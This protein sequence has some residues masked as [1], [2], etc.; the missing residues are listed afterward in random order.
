MT[1]LDN[2]SV[3]HKMTVALA[4]MILTGIA[5]VSFGVVKIM[6]IDDAYSRLIDHEAV[7]VEMLAQARSGVLT[8][9]RQ[10]YLAISARSPERVRAAEARIAQAQ[11]DVH[12]GIDKAAALLPA[13]ADRLAAAKRAYDDLAPV[14]DAVRDLDLKGDRDGA[15]AMMS[16]RFD[17]ALD[18]VR[19][20]LT[21]MVGE[22]SHR[23]GDDSDRL[24]EKSHATAVTLAVGMGI[25]MALTL[26]L[27]LTV[28]MGGI[29]RPLNR[30]AKTMGTLAQGDFGVAVDG[31]ERGDEVGL[32]A[33]SVEVFKKNGLAM[34]R[35][36]RDQ[37]EAKIRA[38]EER[39]RAMHSLADDFEGHMK[40]LVQGVAAQAT[41]LQSTAGS[42]SAAAEETSKQSLAVASGA[43]QASSNVQTVAAASEELSASIGEISRQVAQ[44][45]T[46]SHG[47]VDEARRTGGI[48]ESLA[49]AAGKI[50][51][52]VGLITDIASQTNLLALNATI[53]AARAGEAGKG[54]AVVAG[55][56]K[57]LA[58]QTARA[59]DEIS[60]QVGGIQEATRAAVKAIEGI[61]ATIADI[62]QVATSIASAVEQQGA[63]TQEIARNIQQAAIAAQE[64]SAN[65][66][67]VQQAANE[68][69]A[70]A[71]QVLGAARD[72]ADKSHLLN[73]DVDQFIAGIRA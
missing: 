36:R 53:E 9:G 42:L 69:G 40:G 30:L 67:N 24:T 16:G 65:I 26:V 20:S 68:T 19:D 63:A 25:G 72:L 52:V 41:Q 11:S 60:Q 8:T 33:R 17:P 66:A 47:A 29:S 5:A 46:M 56:V 45:A 57:N 4:I 70:G 44:S 15:M 38:E 22:L 39:R 59:T 34:E 10:Q 12:D 31:T 62:N 71:S 48:V 7:G 37:E 23:M 13:L 2:L 64:V 61:T 3:A 35:M 32:M 49:S 27:A 18:A 21:A 43:E 55:E 73:T 14:G 54:F 28:A 58:N 6:A 50:S 51:E 1:I